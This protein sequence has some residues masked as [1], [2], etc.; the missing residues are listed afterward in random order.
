MILASMI[1]RKNLDSMIAKIEDIKEK[2]EANK[3]EKKKKLVKNE[4]NEE[5]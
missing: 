2:D 4:A 3:D 5:Y 1:A